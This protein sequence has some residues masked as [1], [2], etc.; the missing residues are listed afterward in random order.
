M[1]LVSSFRPSLVSVK[2]E[3]SSTLF[4]AS[5]REPVLKGNGQNLSG[6][7]KRRLCFLRA[8]IQSPELLLLDEPTT[9][10]DCQTGQALWKMIFSLLAPKSKMVV[11]T[12][13]HA[14]LDHFDKVIIL[15]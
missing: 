13:D 5:I 12:H 10:L 11:V 3:P 4:V 8:Y 6:G 2:S 1:V 7:E 14:Y 15:D 9:G